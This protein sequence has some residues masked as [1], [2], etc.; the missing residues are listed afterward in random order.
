[1]NKWSLY[2]GKVGGV[3]IFIHWTF[4][5][6]IS[7][8]LI[9]NFQ[10]GKNLLNGLY[11]IAFVL[12]VFVCVVLHELGHA[13]AARHFKYKTKDIIILPIGGMARMDE[14]PE[15][16]K[17]ELIVSIAGPVVNFLIAL[18][19][20]PVIF[21]Y[22]RIP[23]IF[24]ILFNSPDTF[25]VS[26]FIVN[27]SL[28]LFNLLPAFPMDGGRV[29]R[30]VLSFFIDRVKATSIAARTGQVLA[31]GFFFIGIFYNP[32]LAFAGIF[33]FIIAQAE[34]EYVKSK[35][36][37]HN[38]TVRDVMM[39]KYYSLDA[40]DTIEDAVKGLLDV[41][42]TDFLIIEKGRVI[43]TLNREGIIRGL[44]AKGK[45]SSVLYVMNTKVV[46]LSPEMPLDKVFHQFNSNGHT[47][48]PVIENNEVIGVVDANNI[49]EFIMVRSIAEKSSFQSAK[50]SLKWK[51]TAAL[52]F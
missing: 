24:S 2:L 41:Q 34:N 22:V 32:L 23:A 52:K 47:L 33:I 31:V 18:C 49:L 38:Y 43:G 3:K 1:M 51:E 17:H 35:S 30:A 20:Y 7:W 29:F 9:S 12:S 15:N 44:S 28:A 50:G 26:L 46:F 4:I 25:L 21:W 8:I 11:T 40:F 27:I 5:F 16:P 42:I 6:L 45:E 19:L 48:C 37:L 36:I 14:L 13:F 39:R 10:E